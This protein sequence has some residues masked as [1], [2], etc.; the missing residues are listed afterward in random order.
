[1]GLVFL[2]V[3]GGILGWIAAII[4][5][6][7]DGRGMMLNVAAGIGGALLTGLFV[8]PAF[9]SGDILE[10]H[11]SVGG[12]VTALVGAV[13]VLLLVNLLRDRETG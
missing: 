12:L 3:V 5:R 11:Y 7:E 2:I 10:G 6:A 9:G 8:V 1:M 13:A 4:M